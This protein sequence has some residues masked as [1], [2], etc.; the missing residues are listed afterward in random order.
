MIKS[1][2]KEIIITL[3]L[4]FCILLIICV[5]LYGYIPSQKETPQAVKYSVTSAASS[6]LKEAVTEE[7]QV[8]LTYEVN[9]TDLTNAEKINTYNPGKANPFSTFEPKEEEADENSSNSNSSSSS[10]SSKNSNNN[11]T[12]DNSSTTNNSSNTQNGNTNSGNNT[13]SFLKDKG[14]K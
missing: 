3:L 7:T 2:I 10:S 13:K 8:V 11:N 5:L 4:V 9:A 14:T 12:A 6:A 1:V